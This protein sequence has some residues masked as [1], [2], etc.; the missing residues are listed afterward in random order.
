MTKPV[1]GAVSVWNKANFDS[2]REDAI[3]KI[4]NLL[5]APRQIYPTLPGG[6]NSAPRRIYPTAKQGE[7]SYPHDAQW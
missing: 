2:V 7:F 1:L 4:I 6:R 5:T 3:I